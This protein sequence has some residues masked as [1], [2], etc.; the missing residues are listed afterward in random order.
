M[1]DPKEI[2]VYRRSGWG[3]D[4]I[5]QEFYCSF[6]AAVP[7]ALLAKPLAQTEKDNRIYD[8]PIRSDVAVDTYWDIGNLDATA[9]WFLPT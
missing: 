8:F 2:D 4:R 7:G 1:I 6:R 9:I 3:E 5:Q